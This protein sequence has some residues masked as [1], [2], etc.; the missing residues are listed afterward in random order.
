MKQPKKTANKEVEKEMEFAATEEKHPADLESIE[1]YKLT[2]P[3]NKKRSHRF[4]AL[5]K[6][7]DTDAS[8]HLRRYIFNC[9]EEGKLI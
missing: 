5:C 1:K 8:K 6:E 9:V 4:Q 3:I 2:L 7:F